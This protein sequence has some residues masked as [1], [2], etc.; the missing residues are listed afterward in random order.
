MKLTKEEAAKLPPKPQRGDYAS[1]EEFDE[2]LG[3]WL[4]R[5]QPMLLSMSGETENTQEVSEK[6]EIPNYSYSVRDHYEEIK[7]DIR[8][9]EDN[10]RHLKSVLGD[11][12]LVSETHKERE[13]DQDKLVDILT[14]LARLYSLK[15]D[16][17]EQSL[18]TV[19]DCSLDKLG[20]ID[21][22]DSY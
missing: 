15:F 3:W 5:I 9:L 8:D 22:Y 6:K 11:L 4:H 1:E 19:V 10:T 20:Y 21:S 13:I 17:F 7:E 16:K 18:E 2:H 12:A 14:G